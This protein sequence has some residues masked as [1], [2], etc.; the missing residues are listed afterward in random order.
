MNEDYKVDQ[1]EKDFLDGF[2]TPANSLVTN[3]I[4]FDVGDD[5]DME[6]VMD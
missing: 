1:E 5:V 3:P 6:D 4:T 2:A